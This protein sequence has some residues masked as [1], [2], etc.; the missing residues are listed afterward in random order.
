MEDAHDLELYTCKQVGGDSEF[1]ADPGNG[2]TPGYY[3]EL[4]TLLTVTGKGCDCLLEATHLHVSH[5]SY[6]SLLSQ[7]Q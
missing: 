7:C 1:P 6:R 5:D 4:A 3:N 2:T